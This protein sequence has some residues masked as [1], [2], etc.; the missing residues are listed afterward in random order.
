MIAA[1]L[2]EVVGDPRLQEWGARIRHWLYVDD[3]VVQ[4][5]ISAT[6][7]LMQAVLEAARRRSLTLQLA[8]CAFHV[9]AARAMGK[10]D[11]TTE[12]AALN[13]LIPHRREGL[14]LLGTE[15]CCDQ[16]SPLYLEEGGGIPLRYRKLHHITRRKIGDVWGMRHE[17]IMPCRGSRVLL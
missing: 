13:E 4:A 7:A 10:E 14:M 16:L 12:I 11:L 9:P 1:V 3:W 2:S 15:A 8:K 5:P 6:R 17:N